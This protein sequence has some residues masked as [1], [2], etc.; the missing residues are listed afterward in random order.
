[1]GS[2]YSFVH[3][4]HKLWA[5]ERLGVK[6]VATPLGSPGTKSPFGCRSRG[7]T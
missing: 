2:H 3:L 5:K 1:M 6:H 7:Q 4:K